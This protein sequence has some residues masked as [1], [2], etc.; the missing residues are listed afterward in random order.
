MIENKREQE[1]KR[2]VN[3]YKRDR[4]TGAAGRDMPGAKQIRFIWQGR[5]DIHVHA[6]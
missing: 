4:E 2:E 1:K 6:V 5:E 3:R